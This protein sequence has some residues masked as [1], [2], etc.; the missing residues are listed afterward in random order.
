[1]KIDKSIV[2]VVLEGNV[3][4]KVKNLP[5]SFITSYEALRNETFVIVEVEPYNS[6]FKNE[7]EQ[8][9]FPT[10]SIPSLY[11]QLSPIFRSRKT[12]LERS[13]GI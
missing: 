13:S 6:K 2:F 4:E 5:Y 8:T 12:I 9:P 7:I 1:M 11:S 3:K 10:N